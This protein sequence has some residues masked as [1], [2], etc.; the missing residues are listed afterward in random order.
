MGNFKG[1]YKQKENGICVQYSIGD[2]VYKDGKM[3]IAKKSPILC[4]LPEDLNS[5]WELVQKQQI[6]EN[7]KIEVLKSGPPGP[8]GIP[9]P[10]GEKGLKGDQG[11]QGPI[12][13]PGP[14]GEQGPVG[15][16]GERG[17]KGDFG[18]PPGP[19]GDRGPKGDKGDKG[20][21]GPMGPRGPVGERGPKGDKGDK[22]ERGEPGTPGPQGE[23]GI[24]G[25][26]G[27]DGSQGPKGETG[28]A[29]PKGDKG[30]K[31]DRGND[32][33][34]GLK[35]EPGQPHISDVTHPLILDD[36]VLSF[37]DK[38]IKDDL[39]KLVK[40]KLDAQTIAQNFQW[41]NTG[42]VGGGAVGIYDDGARVIRSVNDINFKG[43]GV[44]VTRKGKQ[45]DVDIPGN[46]ITKA[47]VI[48]MSIAL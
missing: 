1:I 11:T 15:P 12:G 23:Q 42:S 34:R 17:E 20:E 19:I 16:Q 29:G 47:F 6:I 8:Q 10:R 13:P 3:Y 31:G 4:K 21:I 7:K 38:K 32:G 26:D 28:P 9:G 37:D 40:T 41:L 2:T 14:Q 18:G 27:S 25:K 33:P 44:T 22:G 30:Q 43:D 46:S 5:G 39:T 36:G 24:P 45:V 48:A 35:G